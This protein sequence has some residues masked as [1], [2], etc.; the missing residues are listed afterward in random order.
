MQKLIRASWEGSVKFR[1]NDFID[2]MKFSKSFIYCNDKRAAKWIVWEGEDFWVVVRRFEHI[3]KKY[4][5]IC[6]CLEN[7][8][9]QCTRECSCVDDLMAEL[10]VVLKHCFWSCTLY[11]LFVLI[12]LGID[13]IL[14]FSGCFSELHTNALK[15]KRFIFIK[16]FPE[17]NLS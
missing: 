16:I 13:T 6:H 15:N 14:D 2:L 11:P 8:A 7:C 3:L 12:K 9:F 5:E 1:F 4:Q 17:V 10:F